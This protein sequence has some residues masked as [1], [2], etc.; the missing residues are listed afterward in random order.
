M[1]WINGD[2]NYVSAWDGVDG[3]ASDWNAPLTWTG[4]TMTSSI[5]RATVQEYARGI[6]GADILYG[7]GGNDVLS[8]LEGDDVLKRR[9]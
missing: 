8:G 7:G 6:G 5:G 9:E 1:D 3:S 4:F 2:D